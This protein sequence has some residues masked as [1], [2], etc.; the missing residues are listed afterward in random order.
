MVRYSETLD[1]PRPTQPATQLRAL[2]SGC[3]HVTQLRAETGTEDMP[4]AYRFVPIAPE[5]LAQNVIAFWDTLTDQPMFQDIYG[6][7]FGKPAAVLNF[8]RLQRLVTAACR[9][10]LALLISFYD[11]DAIS[12]I[13]D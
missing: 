8:H 3:I 2:V 10:L 5:E 12:R 7:V 4:D 13:S 6:H 9:R 1:C 11:D